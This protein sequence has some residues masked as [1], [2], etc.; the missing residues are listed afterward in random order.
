MKKLIAPVLSFVIA[1]AVTAAIV[2]CSALNPVTK[3]ATVTGGVTNYTFSVDQATLDAECA[4]LG[5]IGTPAVT[6]ALTHDVGARPIVTDIQTAL[7]GALNGADATIVA[8]IEALAGQNAT[9]NAQLTPLI[10]GASAL[11]GQLVAKYGTT[12]A[13]QIG[14][15]ILQEDLTIVTTA[16][17]ATK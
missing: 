1:A 9:V 8:Q 16:L 3:T 11:R 10:Q 17:N 12:V 2:G 13:G 7:N 15:A 5:L 14:K 4:V 6:Y